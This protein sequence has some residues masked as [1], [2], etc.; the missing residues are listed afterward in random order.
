MLQNNSRNIQQAFLSLLSRLFRHFFL[1]C[2]C[3]NESGSGFEDFS[4]S[5]IL[6]YYWY[7]ALLIWQDILGLNEN[8]KMEPI[9]SDNHVLFPTV[10]C[11]TV[12]HLLWQNISDVFAFSDHVLYQT[13]WPNSQKWPFFGYLCF[14]MVAFHSYFLTPPKPC[15]ILVSLLVTNCQY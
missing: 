7:A 2:C 12:F 13:C 5:P 8:N 11:K 15:V 6:L 9:S 1:V 4:C 3:S 14:K 10:L